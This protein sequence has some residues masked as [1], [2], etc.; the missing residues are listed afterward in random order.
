[1]LFIASSPGKWVSLTL[2]NSI[3]DKDVTMH[4]RSAA[5]T[6]GRFRGDLQGAFQTPHLSKLSHTCRC[7]LGLSSTSV[8]RFFS[9]L[10]HRGASAFSYH[11]CQSTPGN[12]A[13]LGCLFSIG[14]IDTLVFTL[15]PSDGNNW[16]SPSILVMATPWPAAA[17]PV[18]WSSLLPD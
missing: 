8:S 4:C 18:G 7:G 3:I 2:L 15:Y 13:Y 9:Y 1:M 17:D 6:S 10:S 16:F 12:F 11:P 14:P 5:A